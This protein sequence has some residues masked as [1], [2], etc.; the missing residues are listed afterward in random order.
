MKRSKF[1][2]FAHK[3][4]HTTPLYGRS[5]AFLAFVCLWVKQ[6]FLYLL[7]H[8]LLHETTFSATLANYLAYLVSDFFVFFLLLI[9]VVLNRFIKN[10]TFKIIN[11]ILQLIILLVFIADMFTFFYFQMRVSVLDISQF[12]EPSSVMSF[13]LIAGGILLA[14]SVLGTGAFL[15]I[16][17][18]TFRKNQRLFLAICC[19]I[20]AVASAITSLYA[21]SGFQLPQNVLSLNFTAIWDDFFNPSISIGSSSFLKYF[22]P[23]E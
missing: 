9:L 13:G 23:V 17:H 5:I 4:L 7:S 12:I 20:F 18:K 8:D 21:R 10:R 14:F 2:A 6:L 22:G 19:S 15:V 1:F 11:N 3:S 16:Q